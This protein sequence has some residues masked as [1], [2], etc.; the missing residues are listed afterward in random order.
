M[1]KLKLLIYGGIIILVGCKIKNNE[2]GLSNKIKTQ[3]TISMNIVE[4]GKYNRHNSQEYD[5]KKEDFDEF[6][7]K[8]TSD[9]V[10]RYSRIKFP[11]KGYN[12]HAESNRQDYVWNKEIWD[13]Y[14]ESDMNYQNN[15]N[16]LNQTKSKDSIKIWRLYKKNSGYDIE[17]RFKLKGNKWFLKYYS[18]KNY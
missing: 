12:S 6:I 1:K 2:D 9:S 7:S 17:Y 18:Y 5:Q 15:E 10:F 4:T 3:D 16:I 11:L 14:S 13:F 8:F